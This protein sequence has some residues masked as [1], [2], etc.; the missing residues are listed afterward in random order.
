MKRIVFIAFFSLGILAPIMANANDV[1]VVSV[2]F[3]AVGSVTGTVI[4]PDGMPIPYASVEL[5]DDQGNLVDGVLTE[6]DGTFVL[7]NKEFGKYTLKITV[8]GSSEYE[9]LVTIDAENVVLGEIN[10]NAEIIQLNATEARG[11]VS[12]IRTE[13]D[14][15][16]IEV[17]KDLVSAGATAG[18][19]LNNIPSLSVDQQSGAL[20]LRGNSNVRVFVDGKPSSIPVEQLL[21]QLPSNSIQKVEIITNPS[22]KYDPDGNSGIINII[23]NKEKSKG[24]NVNTNVGYTRGAKDRYNA[25]VSGNV[26]TGKLNLFGNYNTNFGQNYMRG[27]MQN[28]DNDLSQ[29]FLMPSDRTN[30]LAK[31]GFDWFIDDKTAL[32]IYTNQ[33]FGNMD[34][35]NTSYL[36]F[37]N[38]NGIFTDL[39]L[40]DYEN[41]GGDYSLNFKRDFEKEGHSI[42]FDGF[43][44]QYNWEGNTDFD[45]QSATRGVENSE[46]ATRLSKYNQGEDQKFNNIRLKLDYTIPFKEKGKIESGL[47]FVSEGT[48]NT[49]FTTQNL[50]VY[51]NGNLVDDFEAQDTHFD[52]ERNIYA[53]YVNVGYQW[54][55]IGMQLGLRGEIVDANLLTELTGSADIENET[56]TLNREQT[57]LYPSAFFTYQATENDQFS[58]NYSRRVDR[59]GA[60]QLSPIRQWQ[61]AT[62]RQEGNPN[63]KPQFTDS[64]ELGY[65][66]TV[67]KM[68]NINASVF[69]RK[70]NDEMSRIIYLDEINPEIIIMRSANVDNNQSFGAELSW[71]LKANKWWSLN[72]GLNLY[73]AT[74]KGFGAAN[75]ALEVDNTNFTGRLSNDFSLTNNLKLQLFTMYMGKNYMLQGYQNPMFRQDIG[76]R[77]NFAQGKGTI[78]GR[79]SDIFN[80][81][82]ADVNLDSPLR[83]AG[84]F[85]WESRTFYLGLSYNFGG[86][87][88]TRADK[89]QNQSESGNTGGGIGF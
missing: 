55:K 74:L 38:A 14:K 52:F 68:G 34:M 33:S 5:F 77:Y 10:L 75:E 43:I 8:A 62:A 4:G 89:Q 66:R 6:G 1:E 87:V 48:D 9:Q 23:T 49:M 45:W 29:L 32:T 18:E 12:K 80:T 50:P 46:Q 65:M 69:Y 19:V 28:L 42:E 84:E 7:T 73:Q 21:R 37:P 25:S 72:G 79:M 27:E 30:H 13:I 24:Y 39:S 67:G 59:P 54:E 64:Y 57:N 35:D 58:L 3:E 40:Y 26:N 85:R 86:K 11:E 82:Y 22:A 20:S 70:I 36:T 17:G 44:S 63:L 83:Q 16:V 71:Y 78:S 81:F 51:A 56:S 15:R 31:V 76:L 41:N 53:A 2:K 88:K 60:W 47:N 61:T